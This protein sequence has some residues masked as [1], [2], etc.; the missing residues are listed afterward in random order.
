MKNRFI[1]LLLTVIIVGACTKKESGGEDIEQGVVSM[2][3]LVSSAVSDDPM[4]INQD[5]TFSSLAIYVFNTDATFSLYESVLLPSFS[6]IKIKDIPVKSV[7]GNKILYLIANY[8]GKTFKTSNGNSFS[9]TASTTKQQLDNLITESVSGF[10]SGSLLMVGKRMLEIIPENNGATFSVALHRLQSR[11][12]VHLYKGANFGSNTL[13]LKSVTFHNQVLNSK[14]DFDYA[15]NTPQM[16]NSPMFMEQTV[17]SNAEI[18]P[19]TGTALLPINSQAIFYSFQNLVYNSSPLQSTAPYLEIVASSNGAD[20]TYRGYI[21]DNN[22]TANKYSLLQNNLYQITG[23]LDV[24][25]KIALNLSVLPWGKTNIEYERPITSNDFSFGAWGTSWG[26]LNG[27]TMN[28]NIGGLED[29]VFQFELKAPIGAAWT[30][31][32][33]NGL[34]FAFTSSTAGTAVNAVSKGYANVG[35][36]YLIAVRASKR[37]TGASRDTELYITVEGREININPIVGS[38]RIYQGSD[39]RIKIRQ[40]TSYN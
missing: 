38:Q 24:D 22:Q 37:W 9:L 11:I 3:L 13:T 28:T 8:Q 32:L 15:I 39:T 20:Y 18:L 25:S 26:G 30:A 6:P 5:Q 33:T 23:I 19:Y 4:S 14:I 17:V 7:S 16:L 34:D 1:I 29:A 31:T 10:N 40:I 27:K 36:Q 21:T 35:T 12:D 2:N